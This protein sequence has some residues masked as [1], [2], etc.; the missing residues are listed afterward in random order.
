MDFGLNEHICVRPETE[1]ALAAVL[2]AMRI[3]DSREGAADITSKGGID[4]VTAADIRSE[5]CIRECLGKAFPSYPIIGE[6]RGGS[7][8]EDT[9]YWL[10]DPICG[11][12]PYA[13]NIPLYCCNIALV[14]NGRV[15]AAAIGIGTTG[16][17]LYGELGKGAWMR[18]RNG[19]ARI[20]VSD[21][22]HAL[23]FDGRGA[24][25]AEVVRR[26]ILQNRWFVWQFSSSI[27]YPYVACGRMAGLVHCS[28]HLSAVHT[29]AGCFITEQ[30]GA[31]ITNLDGDPWRFDVPG[32]IVAAAP[33]LHTDLHNIVSLCRSDIAAGKQD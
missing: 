26:T 29:A 4:L 12:R 8:A 19:D 18:T 20:N 13:S 3:I 17:I 1:A 5:D 14:E 2:E 9:P 11:T 22:S 15:T 7:A 25:A 33:A 6:E 10:V 31:V 24:L 30:A 27:A 32:Y 21:S 16:E 28:G 23:W